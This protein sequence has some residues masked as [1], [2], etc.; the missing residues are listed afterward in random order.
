MEKIDSLKATPTLNMF[1]NAWMLANG[2][3]GFNELGTM[4]QIID[5]H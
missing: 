3:R 5:M 4:G 1:V 2:F